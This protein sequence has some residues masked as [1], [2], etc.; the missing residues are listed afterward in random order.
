MRRHH[1]AP[2]LVAALCL[3]PA[4]A[5]AVDVFLNGTKV[6]GLISSTKL[7]KCGVEF[8]AKGDLLLSCPGIKLETQ[9]GGTPTTGSKLGADEGVMTKKYFLVTEQA[10]QG[11]AEFDI[12]L[13]VNAKPVRTLKNDEEQIVIDI[14]KHISPGRNKVLFVA[15]KKPL[16][17]ARKSFSPEHFFRVIIGEGNAAGDKVMIDNPVITFKRTAAETEDVSEEFVLT[18]R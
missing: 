16:T 3:A 10:A 5:L 18:T 8:D 2:L 14:T 15:R 12:D 7:E 4:P 6:N 1:L 17:G 13:Y 11:H 9:G